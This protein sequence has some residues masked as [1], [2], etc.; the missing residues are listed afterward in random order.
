MTANPETVEEAA[1]RL[2]LIAPGYLDRVRRRAAE[3]GLPRTPR[4]GA[5]RSINVVID[6]SRL[7]LNV[8][9]ASKHLPGRVVKR[10]V[11]VLVRFYM[12][13]VAEQIRDLGESTSWMGTALYNY[14]SGLE[15]EVADLRERVRC[16]EEAQ[17]R[18]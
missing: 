1:A 8:P 14:I 12:V 18:P 9:T 7:N 4:D 3:L 11:A 13:F 15:S 17:S 10:V 16:L 2:E 6:S 5:S